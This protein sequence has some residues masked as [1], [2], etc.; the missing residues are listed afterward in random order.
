MESKL[1]EEL[2]KSIKKAGAIARGE[3]KPSRRYEFT[4]SGVRPFAR[5]PRCY[6]RSSPAS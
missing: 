2:T 1:F 6:K 4:P 5:R 3:S